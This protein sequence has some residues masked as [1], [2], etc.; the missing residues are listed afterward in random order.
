MKRMLTVL[1]I[2]GMLVLFVGCGY[3][4]TS[5]VSMKGVLVSGEATL[6]VRSLEPNYVLEIV[7]I[8]EAKEEEMGLDSLQLKIE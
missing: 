8:R 1:V 6:T 7:S 4:T 5:N 3:E 2:I